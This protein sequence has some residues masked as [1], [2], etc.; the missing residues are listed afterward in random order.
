MSSW[1]SLSR[2]EFRGGVVIF[3]VKWIYSLLY[4]IFLYYSISVPAFSDLVVKVFWNLIFS[5]YFIFGHSSIGLFILLS[6]DCFF[7]LLLFLLDIFLF[8]SGFVN[9]KHDLFL[10]PYFMGGRHQLNPHQWDFIL[11]LLKNVD[12]KSIII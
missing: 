5:I 3:S 4:L 6:F 11:K 10:Y 7:I 1:P 8:A 12:K 2:P 9:N